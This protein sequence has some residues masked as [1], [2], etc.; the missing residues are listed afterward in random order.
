MDLDDLLE[1]FK[2]EK[3]NN[4]LTSNTINNNWNISAI[5]SNSK[6]TGNKLGGNN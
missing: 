2:D 1:E 5:S 4:N 6:E 3:K